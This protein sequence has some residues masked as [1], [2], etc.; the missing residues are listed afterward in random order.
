MP[1]P[2][3]A[4]IQ[5]FEE[6]ISEAITTHIEGAKVKNFKEAGLLTTDHGLVVRVKVDDR[7]HEFQVTIVRRA[8]PAENDDDY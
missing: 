8:G 4:T 3:T 7:L 6:Q 2:T 5:D 1:T